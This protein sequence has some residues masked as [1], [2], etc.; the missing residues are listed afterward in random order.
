MMDDVESLYRDLTRA[1][2][3][4]FDWMV[5]LHKPPFWRWSYRKQ[6]KKVAAIFSRYG[7]VLTDEVADKYHRRYKDDWQLYAL[8]AGGAICFKLSRAL[9]FGEKS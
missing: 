5:L 3:H 2:P 6:H 4:P 1:F 9:G 7:F 8:D